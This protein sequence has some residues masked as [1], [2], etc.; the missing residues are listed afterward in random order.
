[1][2]SMWY[3]SINTLILPIWERMSPV[4]KGCLLCCAT[5]QTVDKS[6]LFKVRLQRISW[7]WIP[8]LNYPQNYSRK[9]CQVLLYTSAAKENLERILV[10]T[11]F[12]SVSQILGLGTYFPYFNSTFCDFFLKLHQIYLDHPDYILLILILGLCLSETPSK[13]FIVETRDRG[14]EDEFKTQNRSSAYNPHT[15][16]GRALCKKCVQTNQRLFLLQLFQFEAFIAKGAL[17]LKST[18]PPLESNL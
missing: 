7:S 18:M 13:V 4:S 3:F 14:A 15:G 8:H 17:S 2:F 9:I 6:L 11:G 5:Y 1:M 16:N 10:D 12:S